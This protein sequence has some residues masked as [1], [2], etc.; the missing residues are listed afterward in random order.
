MIETPMMAPSRGER[1][2]SVSIPRIRTVLLGVLALLLANSLASAS[3]FAEAGPFWHHRAVGETGV[4][5]KIEEKSPETFRGEGGEQTLKGSIAGTAIEGVA[6]SVQVKGI[7]YNNALQGQVK[8]K[9]TLHEPRLVKPNLPGCV[10]TIGESN[11]ISTLGHLVWKWDGTA[12]QLTEAPGSNQKPDGIAV[13]S[14]IAAGSTELPKGVFTTITLKGAACG[15][16]IGKYPIEGSTALEGTPENLEEW[17]TSINVRLP[18]GK[19]KQHFWNGK[20]FIGVETG[21]S[22]AGSEAGISG[23]AKAKADVQ[24]VAAFEK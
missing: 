23:E 13:P 12:K 10:T 8:L 21:L 5:A 3:A 11:T 2:I 20:T 22:S 24:E 16:L 19:H 18:E 14:E 15:V 9:M 7:I 17:A 1:R 6:T 4:G